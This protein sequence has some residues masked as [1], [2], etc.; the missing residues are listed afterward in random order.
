MVDEIED[1]PARRFAIVIDEVH[2]SQ[3]GNAA[4][5]INMA[6]EDKAVYD[7]EYEEEET[8]E[9]KIVEIIKGCKILTNA[10]Y[11]VFTA[12]PKNK[13]LELFGEK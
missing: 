13:T 7:I 5:K 1:L 4:G 11:F 6:L 3:S 2:C 10:S 9:D 12:T 8:G